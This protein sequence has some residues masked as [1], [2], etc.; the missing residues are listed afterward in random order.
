MN[1]HVI[2]SQRVIKTVNRLPEEDRGPIASALT[3]EWILRIKRTKLLNPLQEL[4][5]SMIRNYVIR[6]NLTSVSSI[7]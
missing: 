3:E 2:F 5:Y 6:D 4:V 1:Q 7:E